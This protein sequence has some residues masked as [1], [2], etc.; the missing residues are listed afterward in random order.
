MCADLTADV[1][2]DVALM[3]YISYSAPT[4]TEEEFQCTLSIIIIKKRAYFK[5]RFF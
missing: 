4:D 2:G 3:V 5:I 1:R